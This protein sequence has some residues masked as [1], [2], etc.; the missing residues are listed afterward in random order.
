[1]LP[2]MP[3]KWD[4]EEWGEKFTSF[5]LYLQG[6][7]RSGLHFVC[8]EFTETLN[9]F[10]QNVYCSF[11]KWFHANIEN[12]YCVYVVVPFMNNS[13]CL[14]CH[15]NH[16]SHLKY[17]CLYLMSIHKHTW[18][19]HYATH[20]PLD[21]SQCP[22]YLHLPIPS[23]PL[24]LLLFKDTRHFP[25]FSALP[26]LWHLLACSRCVLITNSLI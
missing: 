5:S 6:N 22:F 15:F 2:G 7:L 21:P 18:Y 8:L 4:L 13:E 1:M 23:S 20:F 12:Y 14:S 25:Y 26:V 16:S 19:L 3:L 17:P 11:R 24:V 9:N 10:A